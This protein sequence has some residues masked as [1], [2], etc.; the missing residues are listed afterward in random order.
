MKL[1][2]AVGAYVAYKQSLG[3]RFVTEARTLKSFY[4]SLDDA[5]MNRVEPNLVEAFLT[6]KSPI[7]RFWHRKL[8]ALRGFYRFALARGYATRSPLPTSV[9]EQP[10]TF[11]P[12]IYS[13]EDIKRLL[14]ATAGRE[15]CN[16]SSLT[17]HTLLLL[18]Y[19]TGLRISEAIGLDLADVDL[20][21]GILCI[22][23]TKF[24]KTRLVPTGPD[25]TRILAGYAVERKKRPPITSDAPFLLTQRG[26]RLS[27]AG[28]EYA[29]KQLRKRARV[30]RDDNARYQP[31]LH[32]IRHTFA[33]SRLLS[34]YR[35]GADVQRLL[36]QLATYL[37]H[38]HIAG[39]QHYLTMTPELLLEASLRFER[40]ALGGDCHE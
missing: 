30:C 3:M 2:Q 22:R 16:L 14:A 4:R 18:L 6:G 33:L 26:Q 15:R 8:D 10:Q 39:T 38:V 24:Y 25:L 34:W 19:G 11:V 1:S 12:Y 5:D 32:D 37:G 20:D 28:A 40:Y 35:E 27:R 13:R 9:P 23:E 31:R 29:F 21:A 36:P 17:C 7:T